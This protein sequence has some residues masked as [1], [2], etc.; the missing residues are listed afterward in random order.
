MNLNVLLS[1]EE[2]LSGI[3]HEIICHV[4]KKRDR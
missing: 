2:T 3:L 4:V 1:N